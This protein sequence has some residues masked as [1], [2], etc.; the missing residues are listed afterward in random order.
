[1]DALS[2]SK[3]EY[4]ERRRRLRAALPAGLILLPGNRDV[5]FNYAANSY[6]FRQDSSFLYY[7]GIDRPGLAGLLD[8]EE[9][10]DLL[11]GEDGTL[12]DV[13]WTGPQA[14][15]RDMAEA[16]GSGAGG[17]LDSLGATL[18][19]ALAEGRKVHLLP[20][21]RGDHWEGLEGLF[22]AGR[23][24]LER[25]VSTRLVDAVIAQRSRKS[26]GE[27]DEIE[28]ALAVTGEAFAA[29]A[30]A[31]RPGRMEHEVMGRI[32]GVA[33][34]HGRAMAYSIICTVRGDRLH[35]HHHGNRLEAGQL[36]LVDAGAES[37]G[38]Y[39]SDIT[40]TFPVGGR[41]TP[42]QKDIHQI[43]HRAQSEAIAALAPGKAYKEVHL[44]A[45]AVIASGLKD[46]G[47][48][49]GR[50]ED[51]VAQGVHAL[52]F[53]HGLGH[54]LGL[55]VHDMEGLGE[56]RVGYPG[57]QGRSGQFGLASLRLAKAL[58]PGF[59]LTVEPGIYFIPALIDAWRSEGRF[60]EFIDY[61]RVEAFR[62]F[63]GI[64]IE[65]DV[66]VTE[67]KARVLGKPIP[68]DWKELE[69]WMA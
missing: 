62:G 60:A 15:V 21:Y 69:A 55:D 63:G 24:A 65:D 6:P 35:N 11:F 53:P 4:A 10:R 28:N 68:R 52:C 18:R 37:P 9:G 32:A 41:F 58:E 50:V 5:A 40:R 36:L 1:M 13:V 64:R 42:E 17:S 22:G 19:E 46:M 61:G 38:H 49:R 31:A 44:Q 59:V 56:D 48:L 39:A 20:P 3:E 16:A 7:F 47:L 14:S 57:G 66:L 26:Q 30:Q 43:V 27:I 29:A 45:A 8:V 33:A 12:E 25:L 51:L 67:G 54:M 2:F 34:S 23:A